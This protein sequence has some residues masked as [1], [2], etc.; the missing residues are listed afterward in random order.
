MG[1]SKYD[2]DY[3]ND[4]PV[5]TFLV[6]RVTASYGR[7]P[8]VHAQDARTFY[9]R[10]LPK[11]VAEQSRYETETG[12]ELLTESPG[13]AVKLVSATFCKLSAALMWRS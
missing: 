9:G 13:L 6:H 1:L 4:Q 10:T 2:H 5:A 11:L 3:A 12:E 8:V 7:W